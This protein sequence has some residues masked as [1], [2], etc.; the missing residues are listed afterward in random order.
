MKKDD[1]LIVGAGLFGATFARIMTNYGFKCKIIDKRSH[2]G[3]NCHTENKC[4]INVHKYGP[5]IF[6]TNNENVWRFVNKF[7]DFNRYTHTVKAN[8]KHELYSMP[9]NL[10]TIYKLW[11]VTSP[12]MATEMIKDKQVKINNPKNLEEWALSQ[13]GQELYDLLIKGYTEKQ[14]GKHP[15]ELPASIIKRLPIRY[16]FNDNYFND[17][18]QGVPIGGYT[19]MFENMLDGIDVELN[20]DYIK[21]RDLYD[22]RF[23][24]VVYTGPIDEFFRNFYGKLEWRSLRFEDKIFN[25]DDYQGTAIINYTHKDIPFT[26]IIEHKHFENTVNGVTVITKEFPMNYAE[27]MEK[28]YPVN[29]K[30]NNNL[31]TQYMKYY[32]KNKFIFGGRL[33]EY[34]YYDMHQVIGSAMKKA[35]NE[36]EQMSML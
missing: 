12:Q 26:R 17:V 30:K 14:W 16:N 33:A 22:H 19:K 29:D 18:Y 34:K 24:K 7:A 6:H 11:G 4:G 31:F 8:Y 5:H 15:I 23:K 32:N 21:D 1:Y 28:Y 2:I 35:K 9:I 25:I 27:G 20:T 3:G 36:L 10:N 13:V